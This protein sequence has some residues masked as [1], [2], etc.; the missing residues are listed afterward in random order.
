LCATESSHCKWTPDSGKN[1]DHAQ[2]G[3]DTLASHTISLEQLLPILMSKEEPAGDNRSLPFFFQGGF[4]F[5]PQTT[6]VLLAIQG[7]LQMF[8]QLIVFPWV[9]QKLGSL[10][11][12]Y[13]TIAFYPFLYIITPYLALLPKSFRIPGI[14]VL[15]VWK[16]TAQSLSYPSLAI[17]LANASPSKKVLGTLNGTAAAAASISRGFGPT[18]SGAVDSV[19]A[20]IGMS[21]LA[22]WTIAGVA[23]LGWIPGV[24]MEEERRRPGFRGADD[25]EVGLVEANGDA[26][27]DAESVTT[28]TPDEGF[29][30]TTLP[31]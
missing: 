20:R 29:G 24:F 1:G 9:S 8:A 21:G 31:K 17:M 23:L 18:V 15:L 2:W 25:E 14:V 6:G 19:G 10:R 12:F 7:G 16:V 30:T 27:S 26:E 5:S 4:H 3:T 13:L 22:W 11:T 28:L